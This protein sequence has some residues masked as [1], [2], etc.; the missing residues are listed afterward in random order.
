[1][2]RISAQAKDACN[3]RSLQHSN[4]DKASGSF[5]KRLCCGLYHQQ[6]LWQTKERHCRKAVRNYL[7]ETN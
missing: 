1:M 6:V 3:E 4:L 2:P 7:G 5:V